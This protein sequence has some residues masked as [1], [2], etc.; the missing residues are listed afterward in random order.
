MARLI[1]LM[2][3]GVLC[4]GGCA[5]ISESRFNPLNIFRG[6]DTPRAIDP[7]TIRPLVPADR[8]VQSVDARPLVASISEL[9]V[10]PTVGGVIVRA[11]GTATAGGAYSADLTTA[12]ASAEGITLDFRAFQGRGPGGGQVTVA[13]FLSDAQLGSART[14]S[15][16]S[17]SN[18]LSRRR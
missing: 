13:R 18:S 7:A 5:R 12:Q 3:V 1:C 11:R 9:E 16:R 17:A 2:L 6:D 10:T 15:V 4:L 8:V 14:V